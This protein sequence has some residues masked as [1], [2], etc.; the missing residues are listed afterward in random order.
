M[1]LGDLWGKF[2]VEEGDANDVD[3]AAVKAEAIA[4]HENLEKDLQS[5]RRDRRSE[6]E[7]FSTRKQ[8]ALEVFINF[9]LMLTLIKLLY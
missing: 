7:R 1:P 5:K 4:Q 3:T 9:K 8:M 6:D 2:H